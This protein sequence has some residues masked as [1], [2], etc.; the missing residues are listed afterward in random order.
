MTS[1]ASLQ[2]C[3]TEYLR[4][5]DRDMHEHR[6]EPT[7]RCNYAYLCASMNTVFI[8]ADVCYRL[9][10]RWQAVPTSW[11]WPFTCQLQAVSTG[12]GLARYI[13]RC[14]I[15]FCITVIAV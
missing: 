12:T 11:K 14:Q 6:D 15:M 3:S 4:K 2:P 10:P 13:W 8:T 9:G 7:A 5:T 1:Q